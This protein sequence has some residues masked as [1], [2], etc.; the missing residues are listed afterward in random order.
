MKS[1]KFFVFLL[2]FTVLLGETWTHAQEFTG[3][4]FKFVGRWAGEILR[5]TR[6]Q[7]REA[8]E[9]P[10]RIRIS[11]QIENIDAK[12]TTF[13]IGPVRIDWN[14]KTQWNGLPAG[15][16]GSRQVVEVRGVL[17]ETSHLIATE[18]VP[19]GESD[20]QRVEILGTVTKEEPQINGVVRLTVAGLPA[21][22]TK[23]VATRNSELVRR[24]DERRPEEQF[25]IPVWNR[26][27]TIGGELSTK[28]RFAGNMK[29]RK[30]GDDDDFRIG[31][32]LKLEFLYPF[33]DN[34]L[35]FLEGKAVYEARFHTQSGRR[36]VSKS[37][38]RD[39]S[40]LFWSNIADTRFSLQVG[41]Q[42][43]REDREW[44][45]DR[46]LDALRL[47]YDLSR[48]H[49]E[50]AIAQELM[51]ISTEDNGIDP[52]Q[53]KVFR[54]LGHTAWLWADKQRL[55]GFFLYNRDHS[56][57]QRVGQTI[58][59]DREDPSDAQLVWLGARAS[60]EQSLDRFGTLDYLFQGGWVGGTER[61]LKFDDNTDGKNSVTKQRKHRV[62]GWG[63]DSA[64]AWE[65][66]LPWRPSLTLGYAFGSGDRT[67]GGK[68][69]AFRQTGLPDNQGKYNGVKR[70]RYYGELLRPELSNLHIWTADLGFRF[71]RSSSLDLAYHLYR[72]VYATSSL[73]DSRLDIDPQG[74]KRGIGQEWDLILALR[75]W[76]HI[77]VILTGS[78][79]RAGSA[80]GSRVGNLASGV[81]LELNYNF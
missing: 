47:H 21:E 23:S 49:T 15:Q 63:F 34:M 18:I 73:R 27:L 32:E 30:G 6:I 24:A 80:Y 26:P 71:W 81:S 64:L 43:F 37:L 74:K 29:L 4:R 75:E 1:I 46:D 79:F 42:N 20:P 72:Q 10:T 11:G 54:L 60:V 59:P 3:R 33:S 22:V 5:V 61:L 76:E 8:K 70:F 31:Q 36:E 16:I 48:F 44:W 14:A 67:S 19:L 41:R 17:V 28:S 7:P 39:Q 77:D 2:I 51:P 25:T 78:V 35:L 13:R 50:L 52:E 55:D 12:A 56:R 68:D 40:W 38:R 62:S 57:R 58:R 45:W 69:T 53:K 66:P 9:D 65:M